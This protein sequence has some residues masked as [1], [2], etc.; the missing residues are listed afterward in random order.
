VS[1]QPYWTVSITSVCGIT[2]YVSFT[3][4]RVGGF[5]LPNEHER[6]QSSCIT[7]SA[8]LQKRNI[9]LLLAMID[10]LCDREIV[11]QVGLRVVPRG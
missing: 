5:D 10:L 3:R 4:Y 8:L 2:C 6:D 11:L 9:E 7:V 1:L